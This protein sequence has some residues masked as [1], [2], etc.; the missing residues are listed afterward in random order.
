[1]VGV[2]N[3]LFEIHIR[4][5]LTLVLSLHELMVMTNNIEIFSTGFV[6]LLFMFHIFN[7]LYSVLKP[8]CTLVDGYF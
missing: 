5:I 8:I 6:F 1:M 2:K 4:K 3:D 7:F